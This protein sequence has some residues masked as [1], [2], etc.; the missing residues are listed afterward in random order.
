MIADSGHSGTVGDPVRI[1]LVGVGDAGAHHARALISLA[2]SGRVQ[3]VAVCA[4]DASVLQQ[5]RQQLALPDSVRCVSSLSQLLT[6]VPCDAVIL[7]TPDGLHA[8]QIIECA[9][10]GKHVLVEKPLALRHSD[11][12]RAIEAAQAQRVLLRV[13]YHLRHHAAHRLVRQRLDSLIGPLRTLSVRWAW[14]DP[15]TDGWR[16]RGQKARF[17]SLAALGT[18]AIDLCQWSSGCR[19]RRCVGVTVPPLS[20]GVDHSAELVLEFESGVLAHVSVSVTHRA[21]PRVLWVGDR[22]E[23]ECIGTLGARGRG[24]LWHRPLQQPAQAVDYEPVDPYAAQLA[25][26]V[27]DVVRCRTAALSDG[28]PSLLHAQ[29]N[30]GLNFRPD[31]DGAL[32]AA[33][34]NVGVLDLLTDSTASLHKPLL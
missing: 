10:H 8:D 26:F 34:E 33:L 32:A 14:P 30:A 24:E 19:I 25:A 17:W 29:P 27:D 6:S 11:A 20:V 5:R 15:A 2:A 21:L 28:A 13:G 1:A 23:I 22:G 31:S 4:R 18:H 16:A 9:A 7:A 3:P 12:K